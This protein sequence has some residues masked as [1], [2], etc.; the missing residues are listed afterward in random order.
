MVGV[1]NREDMETISGVRR[2][3]KLVNGEALTKVEDLIIVVGVDMVTTLD[4]H[5]LAT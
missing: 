2:L 4:G 5:I 3:A 1:M